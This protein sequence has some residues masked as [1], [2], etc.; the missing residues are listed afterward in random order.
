MKYKQEVKS[1]EKT[2]RKLFPRTPLEKSDY[3]SKKYQANI[4]LKR[5]DLTP[6]RSYKIRGAYHLIDSI[7]KDKPQNNNSKF[8]CASAGNHA[9][10]FAYACKNF[11]VKGVIFMPTTTPKQKIGRTRDFGGEFIEIELV[12]D[13]FDEAYEESKKF[14][15]EQQAFFVPPFDHDEIIKAAGTISVEILDQ[16]KSENLDAIVFPVG[17]GGLSAG[18]SL[19]LKKSSPKTQR[20]YAEPAGA[21]SLKTALE[22]NKTFKLNSIDTFV[23]GCAVAKIGEKTFKILKESTKEV[24]LCPENRVAKT[25]LDF[26][27]YTG[28]VLEPAGALS[29]DALHDIFANKELVKKLKGK[30]ITVIISG[31]NFDFSRLPDLEERKLKFDELK[32][33][34]I[35]KLPQR[36]GALR[37]FLNLLGEND[38][39]T[40][41]EYLKKSA[42][43]FGS[44][45]IGIET[46]KKNN[47][48]KLFKKINKQSF[49][50]EDITNQD[51]Y[52]DFIV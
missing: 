3:L 8:V 52:F 25:I 9:Q 31:G 6:V 38:D 7:L 21:P 35:L 5:E 11:K 43:T 50:F 49:E 23:D 17:G 37:E 13:T 19:Y 39:I 40:R 26:L 33:Y 2:I 32:R 22:K 44:V 51:I 46:N 10:G 47:F 18:N 27:Y 30:N 4:Y 34:I 42:K 12:G 36:P 45:L 48:D 1:I 16:L 29:I 20:F 28:I 24:I 15:K 41:F 14:A